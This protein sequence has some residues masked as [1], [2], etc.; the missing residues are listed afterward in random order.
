MKN[1]SVSSLGK[2]CSDLAYANI[3][4]YHYENK[5]WWERK[6]KLVKNKDINLWDFKSRFWCEKRNKIK[7]A[8]DR[9][10]SDLLNYTPKSLRTRKAVNNIPFQIF[11]ISLMIDML[12]IENIKKY[13][14]KKKGKDKYLSNITIKINSLKKG[15]D[16]SIRLINETGDYSYQNEA[17]TF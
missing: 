15:I 6:Q 2:L 16:Y 12:T 10:L 4:V 9:S 17:R 3:M 5:K 1:R 7:N 13:D 11:P 8:I 14:L